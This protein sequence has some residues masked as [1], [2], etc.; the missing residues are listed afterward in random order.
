MGL[1]CALHF[2]PYTTHT[3]T[4]TTLPTAFAATHAIVGRAATLPPPRLRAH[5]IVW[6]V[7]L[8]LRRCSGSAYS[9]RD[10][11]SSPPPS[12]TRLPSSYIRWRGALGRISACAVP[13]R[14]AR[15]PAYWA[16]GHHNSSY[17]TL[18]PRPFPQLCL[19]DGLVALPVYPPFIF[20]Q[21]FLIPPG[22]HGLDTRCCLG[23][24]AGSGVWD[25]HTNSGFAITPVRPPPPPHLPFPHRWLPGATRYY[26]L[27]V[28]WRHLPR[29]SHIPI[30]LCGCALF[31]DGPCRLYDVRWLVCGC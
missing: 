22:L 2:A 14:C 21:P 8:P 13:A 31:M 19:W 17:P 10:W 1:V 16:G 12:S 18:P 6:M 30:G 20:L 24:G 9:G 27:S 11:D 4:H 28:A 15:L 5:H 7:F 23:T 25:L 26:Q 3:Y 29:R